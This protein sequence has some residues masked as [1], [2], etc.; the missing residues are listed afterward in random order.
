MTVPEHQ[1]LLV[2][3]GPVLEASEARW[4]DRLLARLLGHALDR[5]LADGEPPEGS[6]LLAVRAATAGTVSARRRLADCWRE[7]LQRTD[8]DAPPALQTRVPV[9]RSRIVAARREIE[10][11]VA[12]LADPCP[13]PARGV[14]MAALL[15][16]EPS[17][18][19]D[20]GRTD[21]TLAQAVE[22]VLGALRDDRPAAS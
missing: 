1:L 13:V 11:L 8:R 16:T 18:V 2:L 20:V 5:R 17:P 6:R 22:A 12:E 21:T 10:T 14:A 19:Y 4:R 9:S 3:D 15:L 7:L